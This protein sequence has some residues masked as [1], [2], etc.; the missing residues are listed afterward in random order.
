[1]FRAPLRELR[2]WNPLAIRL[3]VVGG[4]IPNPAGSMPLLDEGALRFVTGSKGAMVANAD[5]HTVL[6]TVPQVRVLA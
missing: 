1:M 3:Q 2:I 4:S 6:H 5:W